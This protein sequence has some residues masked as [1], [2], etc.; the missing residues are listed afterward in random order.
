MFRWLRKFIETTRLRAKTPVPDNKGTESISVDEPQDAPFIKASE[1]T[2]DDLKGRF[3]EGSRL[4]L[5]ASTS[6][7]SLLDVYNEVKGLIEADSRDIP[8]H[9]NIPRNCFVINSIQYWA[10]TPTLQEKLIM[11]A[12]WRAM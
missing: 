5:K 4:Q 7:Q 3:Y 6:G 1:I 12:V 10:G 2:E 9:I 8:E 11:E